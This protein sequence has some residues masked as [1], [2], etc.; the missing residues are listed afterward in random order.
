MKDARA[1]IQEFDPAMERLEALIE[2]VQK[3]A[4]AAGANTASVQMFEIVDESTSHAHK[5]MDEA[6]NH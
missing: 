3:D 2:R 1:Y 4:F 5:I 6:L